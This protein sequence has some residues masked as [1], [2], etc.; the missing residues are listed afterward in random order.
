M[1]IRFEIDIEKRFRRPG[2]VI[3]VTLDN[4]LRLRSFVNKNAIGGLTRPEQGDTLPWSD[5]VI[6]SRFKRFSRFS[7]VMPEITAKMEASHEDFRSIR[8]YV[9]APDLSEGISIF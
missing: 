3:W 2:F 8:G 1:K 7:K 4:R 9:K 5:C 6:I